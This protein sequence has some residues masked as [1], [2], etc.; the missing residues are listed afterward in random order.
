MYSDV[1]FEER[2]SN[3][4][5]AMVID[6]EEMSEAEADAIT[7]EEEY[8]LMSLEFSFLQRVVKVREKDNI[9]GRGE[10]GV[11]D[12]RIS[13]GRR[14]REEEEGHEVRPPW[15]GGITHERHALIGSNSVAYPPPPPNFPL[16]WRHIGHDL[17]LPGTD[18][19]CHQR[20]S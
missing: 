19:L 3:S 6:G 20:R 2:K 15:G 17:L 7:E 12:E 4:D 14:G 9:G 13:R 11:E 8:C 16:Y 5:N 18:P 1:T 10:G